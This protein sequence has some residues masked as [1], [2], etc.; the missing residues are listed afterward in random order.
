MNSEIKTSR[1]DRALARICAN[2]PVCRRARRRQRGAAYG[3]VKAIEQKVCPFCRA[4]HRVTG[5][6]A[7]EP[8]TGM[9]RQVGTTHS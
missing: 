2:C 4:Y 8:V 7:H 1:L 6:P 9:A 3:L 5:R